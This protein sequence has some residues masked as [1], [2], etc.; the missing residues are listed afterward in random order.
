MTTRTP[1]VLNVYNMF[2]LNEYTSSIG[3]GV[4]H[5]GLEVY[6]REF[7]FGGHPFEFTGVFE[8]APQNVAEELGEEFIF[9]ETVA[10]GY[11]DFSEVDIDNLLEMLGNSYTGSSYHLIE[12]NCNH[13]TAELGKLLTGKIMPTWINRLA[14][15]CVRFPFL[16]ACI[17]KEWLRPEGLGSLVDLN[18][19]EEID[20]PPP[21][22]G[23]GE[24][25]HRSPEGY[26]SPVMCL[27]KKHHQQKDHN[28]DD[29][30]I[31]DGGDMDSDVISLTEMLAELEHRP[32]KHCKTASNES[33]ISRLDVNQP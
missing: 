14:T 29:D 3:L 4:Y 19:W 2:W 27:K 1:V 7:A 21:S 5:S 24:D 22:N 26:S 9:K 23:D 6:G 15:I 11:T 8:I 10:L 25:S 31:I 16:A 33:L 32:S 18:E 20:V 17:P 28:K 30:D 12:R 13:F